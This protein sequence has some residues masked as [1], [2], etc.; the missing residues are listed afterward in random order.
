M[1]AREQM[2]SARLAE[3]LRKM[4]P[5]ERAA[6]WKAKGEEAMR[7]YRERHPE[8]PPEPVYRFIVEFDCTPST[9]ERIKEEIQSRRTA[10]RAYRYYARSRKKPGE[11]VTKT[12][13]SPTSS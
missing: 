3:R 11:V 5:E 10:N 6:Y 4:T 8:E 12:W 9:F 7:A 2:E 13:Q 1:K